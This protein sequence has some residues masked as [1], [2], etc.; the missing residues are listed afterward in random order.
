MR[1]IGDLV[2]SIPS[3]SDC[4]FCS[5]IKVTEGSS[6]SSFITSTFSMLREGSNAIIYQPKFYATEHCM[7]TDMTDIIGC[8]SHLAVV[9]SCANSVS[10]IC[11]LPV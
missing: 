7:N 1:I 4:S 6:I 10:Y 5:K 2:V 8:I 3:S 11:I 9:D